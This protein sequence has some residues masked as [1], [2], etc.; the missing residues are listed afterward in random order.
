M[1]RAYIDTTLSSKQPARQ[2]SIVRSLPIDGLAKAIGCG[3]PLHTFATNRD[4]PFGPGHPLQLVA[5]DA[6]MN[7]YP[8]KPRSGVRKG[9]DDALH[10]PAC[11]SLQ[12]VAIRVEG[13]DRNDAGCRRC[14]PPNPVMSLLAWGARRRSL[15][16]AERSGL[17]G[18]CWVWKA[19]DRAVG[20]DQFLPIVG[21]NPVLC[22]KADCTLQQARDSDIPNI[23]RRERAISCLARPIAPC[24]F[25]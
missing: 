3:G 24:A 1:P 22:S 18:R 23:A 6:Q 10:L 4:A 7:S 11:R 14:C 13:N 19:T 16:G 8:D 15:R 25:R 20:T 2:T 12:R 17:G 9:A 21:G 5:L